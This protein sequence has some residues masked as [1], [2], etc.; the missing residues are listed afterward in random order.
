MK[1]TRFT[2]QASAIFCCDA[3]GIKYSLLWLLSSYTM[4]AIRGFTCSQ[5]SNVSMTGLIWMLLLPTPPCIGK[6]RINFIHG[7]KSPKSCRS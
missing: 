3:N 5:E 1:S 4:C 7:C 6:E 2:I